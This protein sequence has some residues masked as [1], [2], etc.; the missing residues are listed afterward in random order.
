VNT[1]QP[2]PSY[3]PPSDAPSFVKSLKS[4][5]SDPASVIPAAIFEDWAV[6]LPGPGFPLVVAHPE[7]V[8]NVLV[9]KDG[10]FGRDRQLRRLMRRAWG[11]GLAAAEG[12]AWACQRR[13]ASPAFRPA[14]VQA[15]R[16]LMAEVTRSVS[17][18][19]QR[20]N[21]VELASQIGRIV[22]EI[23][24]RSL[25]SELG[26][27]NYDEVARDIP[28][29][30]SEVTTFGLLDAAPLPDRMVNRLRGIGR[31]EEEMRLRA[32]AARISC[33]RPG[34]LDETQHLPAL[35]RGSGP[36]QDNIFGFM[37]AGFETTALGAAW[38]IY[39][40]ANYPEWQEA[41]R[42]EGEGYG[43][44]NEFP[45]SRQVAMEALRLYPPAPLL[46]RK[47]AK[48][49]SIQGHRLLPGQ[50]IL[51]PVYAIHRHRQL[52]DRPDEFDP[53]R[54]G[55]SGNYDRAAY[56]PFGAGPRLCIAAE[57]ALT[58]I[59]AIVAELLRAFRFTP[60]Q[61]EPI[62]SLRVSTHSLNGIYVKAEP[63]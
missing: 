24:T 8:R 46:V 29:V 7:D 45:I 12:E 15:A 56:L 28:K 30:V 27:I 58:E 10:A 35:L 5:L 59:A 38:V 51:I 16:P 6:K 40:L 55:S 49:T 42:L 19:W 37:L 34:A 41:A 57:F 11:E 23:V 26:G 21:E 39:L 2:P 54:F 14:A 3:L 9:N 63:L 60:V 32:V 18:D 36:I 4:I 25:L 22:T 20:D 33:P 44:A 48:R 43:R 61:P 47:T 31:S 50:A 53:G 1:G 52:W 13:A 62:V 17:Q